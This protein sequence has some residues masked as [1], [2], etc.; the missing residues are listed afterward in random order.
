MSR[1]IL[2][3]LLIGI[4][5]LILGAPE[6][7]FIKDTTH[8]SMSAQ[9]IKI[10]GPETKIGFAA[11][12]DELNFGKIPLGGRSTKF[13]DVSNQFNYPAKIRLVM[14][15]NITPFV[16]LSNEEMIL[17]PLETGQISVC[18]NSRE[19][20][21]Y[22]GHINIISYLPKYDIGNWVLKYR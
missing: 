18:F 13:I 2:V 6:Y 22:S 4:G 7:L 16:D 15:G 9:V 5:V 19:M 10:T 1:K 14:S 11:Q 21:N 8:F 20:G 17:G 12:T 3:I